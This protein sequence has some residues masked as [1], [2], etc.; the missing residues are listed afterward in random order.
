MDRNFIVLFAVVDILILVVGG[1]LAYSDLYLR[2]DTSRNH[3]GTSL[4]NVEYS[5]LAYRPTYEYTEIV[6]REPSY[7]V[8]TEGSWTLDF[9]QISLIVVAVSLLWLLSTRQNDTEKQTN[10]SPTHSY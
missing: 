8:V 3:A 4:I 9:F 6:N 7:V 2:R 10:F 1:F 5:P